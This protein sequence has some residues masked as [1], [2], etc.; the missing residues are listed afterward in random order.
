MIQIINPSII[1]SNAPIT[2]S[3][4]LTIYATDG[5]IVAKASGN[6]I[7]LSNLL[8]G[9]YSVQVTTEKKETTGSTLIRL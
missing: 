6:T 8:N 7:D 3:A 1:N 2:E 5:P 4:N 9:V